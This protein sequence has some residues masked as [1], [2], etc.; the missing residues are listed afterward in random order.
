MNLHGQ[1]VRIW[2]EAVKTLETLHAVTAKESLLGGE[3]AIRHAH[4][5]M[6]LAEARD[7]LANAQFDHA[8]SS[9]DG[10]PQTFGVGH[11]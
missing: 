9:E 10:L 2:T 3:Q 4:L 11:A 8:L 6:E 7:R 1:Q 5:T